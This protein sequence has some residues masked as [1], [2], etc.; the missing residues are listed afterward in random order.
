[1]KATLVR[2]MIGVSIADGL[3]G[4]IALAVF[5]FV[6]AAPS[7]FRN[8]GVMLGIGVFGTIYFARLLRRVSQP[9]SLP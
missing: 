2:W 9:I 5:S 3:F 7:S 4:L 6:G 8:A 1:V